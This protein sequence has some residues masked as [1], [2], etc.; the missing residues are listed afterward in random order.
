MRDDGEAWAEV[1]GHNRPQR[2]TVTAHAR[3]VPTS[4]LGRPQLARR[5]VF[6][7]AELPPCALGAVRR[8]LGRVSLRALGRCASL[9]TTS[10]VSVR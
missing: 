5:P 1:S 8:G 2:R 10:A 7:V 4:R 6:L 9:A 3:T